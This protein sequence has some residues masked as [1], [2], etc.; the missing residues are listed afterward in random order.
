MFKVGAC[1]F[2]WTGGGAF[3]AELRVVRQTATM[4]AGA[5]SW[6]NRI[7]RRGF[8]VLLVRKTQVAPRCGKFIGRED[9]SYE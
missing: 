1:G 5:A 9:S 2:G 4:R 6:K 7:A 3:W 8:M